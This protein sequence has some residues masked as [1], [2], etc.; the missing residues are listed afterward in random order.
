MIGNTVHRRDAEAAENTK[1][2]VL[3]SLVLCSRFSPQRRRSRRAR[4]KVFVLCSL[5][6]CSRFS[7]QR[8]RDRREHTVLGSLSRLMNVEQIIRICHPGVPAL[9]GGMPAGAAAYC[10]ASLVRLKPG[11]PISDVRLHVQNSS[12]GHVAVDPLKTF[13][14]AAAERCIACTLRLLRPDE[15]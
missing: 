10:R 14:R 2:F 3:C 13:L 4:T 9:A 8:R 11:L 5:V 6:L 7:P 15:R 1:V 12:G